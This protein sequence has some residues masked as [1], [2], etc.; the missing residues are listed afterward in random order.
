MSLPVSAATTLTVGKASAT[1]DALVAVDIGFER[2][3]FEKHGLDLKIVN[4][5]GG[6]KMDQAMAAGS[7]TSR[8]GDGTDIY[9]NAR[10][11]PA[12]GSTER[13]N[14]PGTAQRVHV[15]LF[16]ILSPAFCKSANASRISKHRGHRE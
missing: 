9:P 14:S 5:T 6:S 3:I 1:S 12:P 8:A 10:P 15:T 7:L 4:F 16:A 2:G 13:V 11:G